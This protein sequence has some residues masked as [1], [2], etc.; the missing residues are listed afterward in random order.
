[1]IL[2]IV[3]SKSSPAET[4]DAWSK[5]RRQSWAR[6]LQKVYEV[7]PFICLKCSGTM[8][9]VAV[10]EDPLELSKIIKWAQKQKTSS[11]VKAI[12]APPDLR[13]LSG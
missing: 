4:P 1:V 10:I 8:S 2:R 6:L 9:V 12:R 3:V 11:L 13:L 5:L 7:N